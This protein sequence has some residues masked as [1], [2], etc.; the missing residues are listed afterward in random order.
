[1][2]FLDIL[3]WSYGPGGLSKGWSYKAGTTVLT[4]IYNMIGANY[5]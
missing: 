1:M 4:Y 3:E 2:G 5:Q